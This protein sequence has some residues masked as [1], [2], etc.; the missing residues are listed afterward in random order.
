LTAILPEVAMRAFLTGC[1][2]IVA[3]AVPTVGNAQALML[4]TPPPQVTALRA[5]WQLS[6]DPVFFEGDF[7]YPTGP[8]VYFDGNVMVRSGMFRGVPVFTDTTLEPYSMVFVPVGGTVM[9][10]YERRRAGER[11][12][13]VG[14]RMPSFPIE[15]DVELSASAAGTGMQTPPRGPGEPPTMAEGERAVAT[16]GTAVV[17]TPARPA[18]AIERPRSGRFLESVPPPRSNDGVWIPFDNARWYIAGTAVAFSADRFT[19]IGEYRG[20]PV[21]RDEHGR[22]DEIFVPSI[23]GGPLVP[24]RR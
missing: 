21:Y 11:A 14:S 7:Y 4:P 24:Y 23:P 8:T 16:G 1:V 5:A 12:G 18:A 22:A 17:T 3:L 2:C 9:R 10:P 20:F 19:P 15:R 6:G 13:T